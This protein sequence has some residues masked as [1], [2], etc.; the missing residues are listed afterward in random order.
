MDEL[1]Q[2][3][4]AAAKSGQR[5]RAYDLLMQ[6]VEEDKENVLAWLWLSGVADSLD[7][8]EI[9][10][11]NV[12]ALDPTNV[13]ARKGLAQVREQKKAAASAV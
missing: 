12:L 13:A 9:C 10:L 8:R 11:E 3:G 5:E 6:V 1:L 7:D 4:I 2:E